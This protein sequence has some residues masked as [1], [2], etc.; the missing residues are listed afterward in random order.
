VLESGLGGKKVQVTLH[1]GDSSRSR[2]S[3][4]YALQL[5]LLTVSLLGFSAQ[6]Q[7]SPNVVL[8]MTDDQ[9]WG[10]LA[11]HGNPHIKTP[12]LDRLAA[13]SVEFTRF[14]VSPVCAPTRASLLTGRYHL[15]TGAHGV[16][17]GRET[18]WPGEVTL[19][20]AFQ[21]AGYSTALFGKWHLGEHYP[22]VPHGQGFD[23]FIG[24]RTGHWTEYFNPKLERNGEP[25]RREG[26]IADVL[27]DESISF[28]EQHR[29]DRFFLYIPYNTPHSPFQ[30]PD[31]YYN[32]YEGLG[33]DARTRSAYAM[34]T[35]IDDNVGRILDKLDEL[36]L[37]RS[38]IVIFLTDNGPNGDRFN[39]GL[40][41]RKGDV[42]EGGVRVPFFIRWP[43]G[44]EGGR[45]IERIAAHIDVYPTLLELCGVE[46]PEGPS[47]DG[48]SLAGL[49]RG[50][51][52]G[53]PEDRML[54]THRERRSDP[55][56]PYPGAVRTQR[57]NLING[58]E[59]YD[60]AA[61]PGEQTDVASEHPEAVERLRKA[62]KEW[63]AGVSD[64]RP[65]KR[66]PIPVGYPQENPV[67]LPAPQAR[68]EG[69]V[70][71]ATGPGWA[72]DWIHNW[73]DL[74]SRVWWDLDVAAA[75]RYEAVLR[76]LCPEK[77]AGAKVK[78]TVAGESAEG[79]IREPTPMTPFD[80]P[81]RAPRI[82]APEMSWGELNLGSLRLPEGRTRAVVEALTLPG[83]AAMELKALVLRR[84]EETPA[85]ETR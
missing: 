41:G 4:K 58:E 29:R 22:Y 18:M 16:T 59:L 47:I 39:G 31:R 6:A 36:E 78:L 25:I 1:T 56:A 70:E 8:I 57:F 23:E 2:R 35:N 85:S 66:L 20:E 34:V 65:H 26:Y 49:L 42:Y 14:Y 54:F 24:F 13:E 33:L 28:L 67:T 7:P 83:E 50:E 5:V 12:R 69:A 30:V 43:E 60:V 19:G 80:H 10:D 53:L 68:L 55:W 40:R 45:K 75:G 73:T 71:F 32:L 9:G 37:A 15:R 44:F 27:T 52:E 61:E 84:L 74:D 46:R 21:A 38:T 64:D 63:F 79:V 76:Y 3:A 81:D 77:D 51:A 82:E 17:A 62:Y 11:S 72:H 48:V